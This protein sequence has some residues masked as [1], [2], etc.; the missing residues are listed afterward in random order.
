MKAPNTIEETLKTL[1]W[2]IVEY[3]VL[4]EQ[5]QILSGKMQDIAKTIAANTSILHDA[6]KK[7]AVLNKEYFEYLKNLFKKKRQPPAGYILVILLSDEK[8]SR[9]PY[10]LPVSYYPYSSINVAYIRDL[11]ANIKLKMKQQNITI[12][13]ENIY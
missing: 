8:R 13:G 9:K 6:S 4:Q 2:E 3:Q 5:C 11:T 12:V 10:A 1:N 7:L